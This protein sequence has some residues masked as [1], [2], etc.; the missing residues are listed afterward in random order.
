M[1]CKAYEVYNNQ[2]YLQ[3]ATEAEE[4]VWKRGLLTRGVGLCHGIGGNGYSFLICY[5]TLWKDSKIN[6]NNNKHGNQRCYESLYRALQFCVFITK[7]KK[8][9]IKIDHPFSLFEGVLGG[10]S[11][12]L[13]ILF[14]PNTSYFPCFE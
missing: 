10:S 9:P 3:Y 14:A 6:N 1:Y 2:K 4:I 12:I 11:L 7:N 13:N 5:R 8:Y